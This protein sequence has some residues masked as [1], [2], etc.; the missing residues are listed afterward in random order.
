MLCAKSSPEQ[1][2]Y[3]GISGTPIKFRVDFAQ[4]DKEAA[5]RYKRDLSL[6]EKCLTESQAAI[7]TFSAQRTFC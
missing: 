4:L 2:K 7:P 3:G 6:L 5:L 1:E